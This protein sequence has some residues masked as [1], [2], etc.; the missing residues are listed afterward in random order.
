[1]WEQLDFGGVYPSQSSLASGE[2]T[3]LGASAPF[4]QVHKGK[5][6]MELRVFAITR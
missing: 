1:M 3:G 2:V 4:S 5:N 6:S